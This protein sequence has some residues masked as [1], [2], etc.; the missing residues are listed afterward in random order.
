M[1]KLFVTVISC[2]GLLLSALPQTLEET[3]AFAM[4]EWKHGKPAVALPAFRRVTFFST[5]H[6]Q[7][8]SALYAARCYAALSE[9]HRGMAQVNVA[10]GSIDNIDTLY[11]DLIL[12]KAFI[13]LQM[14]EYNKAITTL[15]DLP[16]TEGTNEQMKKL[17]YQGIAYFQMGYYPVS[18]SY[19]IQANANDTVKMQIAYLFNQIDVAEKRYNPKRARWFS[20]FIPG[21]GQVIAGHPGKGIHSFSLNAASVA[22]FIILYN[23][24]TP[25]DAALSAFPWIRRFYAGNIKN[26][27]QL[28]FTRLQD[29][30][31]IIY[32]K[33]VEINTPLL[34]EE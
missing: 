19:F 4:D 11:Q 23:Q 9:P 30:K 8:V 34:Y 5:G 29:E 2:L 32:R 17:V 33:L 7:S 26:A 10:L 25:L 27:Y 14:E 20:I 24:Y 16:L 1:R 12:Q 6:L 22:L 3:F 28:S 21:S 18:Q 15:L 13:Y 31:E